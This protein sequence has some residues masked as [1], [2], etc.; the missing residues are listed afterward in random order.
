VTEFV[1]ERIKDIAAR[2]P[3]RPAVRAGENSLDYG[4][5]VAAAAGLCDL[6][7]AQGV[8]RE[9]VVATVVPRGGNQVI[10]ILAIW[11][12]GAAYLPLDPMWPERRRERILAE[13][14]AFVLEES[15]AA[16]RHA[17]MPGESGLRV[18]RPAE[19]REH[20]PRDGSS[21]HDLA[22]VISTSGSTGTPLAVGVESAAVDNYARY[23][24]GLV[25]Q[26]ELPG[27]ADLRVLLSADFSFDASLRPV[28]LLAAGAELVIA[29]NLLEG[30]WQDHIDCIADRSITVLSGVP[31]WYSGI[32]GAGFVPAD[33]SVRLAFI[34]G[35]A[36]PNGIVRKLAS[37]RCAVV[38]Q[39]GPTETTIAAT[40]GRLL[41][42]EFLEP[43]IGQAL[44]GVAVHLYRNTDL[45]PAVDGE[46]AQ[47]Y[48]SGPGVAR[49]YLNDPKRTAE[50]FVPNPS[51]PPGSRMFRTGDLAKALPQGGYSFRGRRDDQVKLNGRRIEL[52]E[53][54]SVLNRHPAVSQSVAFIHPDSAHPLLAACYVGAGGE[55]EAAVEAS[56]REHLAGEL[57]SYAV[58]VLLKR[59][60]ALPVTERGKVDVAALALLVRPTQAPTAEVGDESA[61]TDVE[62]AVMAIVRKTLDV[63]CSI[64]DEL[65]ALGLTSLDSLKILAQIREELGVR[66]RL[67]DFFQARTARNVSRLIGTV[68]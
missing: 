64:D 55:E 36:V 10:A 41:S 9:D 2:E 31:S 44:P 20:A 5:L 13:S 8:G 58:P 53:I 17:A 57:P 4:G 47:L 62:R 30:S 33:S 24:L 65:F 56:V 27:E 42:D 50:R 66:V 14:A 1:L 35:E 68:N 29:P 21:E 34:G 40:G 26:P 12:S 43:P 45:D 67:R 32:I 52:T 16:G 28:L 23:L 61:L 54:S 6:L 39:Y 15:A 51:G 3:A 37:D 38:V 25:T 49:G 63:Q 48:V 18:R 46:P 11:M 22:Y 60:D 19:A 59:L 7:R